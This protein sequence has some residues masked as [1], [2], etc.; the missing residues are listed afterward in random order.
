MRIIL[1]FRKLDRS[2]IIL[3][4]LASPIQSFLRTRTDAVHI[5][6]SSLLEDARDADSQLKPSTETFCSEIAACMEDETVKDFREYHEG[7]DLTDEDWMPEPIDAATGHQATRNLDAIAHL[8]TISPRQA[9]VTELQTVLAT[10]LLHRTTSSFSHELRL[11]NLF[12]QRFEEFH[13]Q[14]CEIMVR[15]VLSSQNVDSD[16]R[17]QLAT[18]SSSNQNDPVD[19]HAMV[20]SKFYWPALNPATFTIP[21]AITAQA[22]TYASYF[23]R[24]KKRRKLEFL[25]G[26]GRATVNLTFADRTLEIE[27]APY[28]AALI[29]HFDGDNARHSP[30]DLRA[31][32]NMDD[33]LV[34]QALNFW[35]AQSVLTHAHHPRNAHDEKIYTP[36]ERLPHLPT[37]APSPPPTTDATPPVKTPADLLTENRDL[38]ARVVEGMLTNQGAM[39]TARILAMMK[40]VLP[41]GF[42]FS[43]EE[44]NTRVLGEMER[45]GRVGRGEDGVWR[46]KR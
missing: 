39:P 42:P 18:H 11:L 40:M 15:D 21:P 3:R 13:I 1:S 9:F 19:F 33:K 29:H 27:C 8:V 46:M 45:R 43:E 23:R 34:H 28:Q 30:A 25:S 26:L 16:I 10:R 31:A 22:Q 41:A 37:S 20:L 17:N 12:K 36:L 35:V 24:L 7:K 2:G 44:L 14:S 4:R 6:L 5:I 38:Y 32:L